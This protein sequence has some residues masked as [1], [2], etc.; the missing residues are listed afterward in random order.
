[1]SA[2]DIPLPQRRHVPGVNERPDEAF[3]AS[4]KAAAPAVTTDA[5]SADN[6]AWHYG[7]RLLN[8]GF[9]WEAHEVLEQ[10][11]LN[12][13]PNSRER[14]LVRGVIHLA[15]GAL[16]A[17]MGQTRARRR[18]AVMCRQAFED[19]FAGGREQLMGIDADE[20]VRVAD[21]LSEGHADTHLSNQYAL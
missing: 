7:L 2:A 1:M 18:L 8:A 14:Y 19:A 5:T 15:N 4:I 21:M 13:A 10:V 17:A 9:Y 20:A 11:W 16:K 3:F 6:L 12:A